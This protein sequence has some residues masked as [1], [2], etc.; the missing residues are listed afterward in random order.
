MFD[1]SHF[2]AK[3]RAQVS[4]S[5][6]L[7]LG[8]IGID[9]ALFHHDDPVDLRED[10]AKVVGHHEDANALPGD[11]A[12]GLAELALGGEVE[13]VGG[14]VEEQHFRLV[15]QSPGDHDASLLAG[16]HFADSFGG[17]VIGLHQVQ[18]FAGAGTHF[19]RDV[20]I[21]PESRGGEESSDNGIETAGHGSTLAG[22]LGRDNAEVRTKLRN[23]PA[24]AAE[25]AELGCGCDDRVALTGDGLNQCGFAA[26]IRTEDGEVLAIGDAERDIVENDVVAA[27]DR[28]I[29][30]EQEVGC[31][32]CA[33]MA[34][35]KIIAE[36]Q[37]QTA[38]TATEPRVG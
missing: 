34:H 28:D 32:R 24:L 13:G 11:A 9:A 17:E 30:H 33:G 29:V 6:Q 7:P 23:I 5:E 35:Q 26:A 31:S 22:E 25:E 2:D 37:G 19:R 38:G 36:G 15:H 18:R 10:V 14:F 20:E 4:R 1:E 21:G 27:G 16:R 8:S 3:E 12:E